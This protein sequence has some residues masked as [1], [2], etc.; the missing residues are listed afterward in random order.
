MKTLR[1]S[2]LSCLA[3]LAMA[4]IAG[5][6]ALLNSDQ[7]RFKESLV[8]TA[9]PKA[10]RASEYML[11]FSGPVGVPGV[12]LSAGSYLFRFP[13]E[14]AKVIQVLKADR[15]DVYA[16]F[17]TI[18]AGTIDRSKSSDTNEVTW[19]ERRIDAPP[20]IKAWFPSGGSVGYE[21][22][23]PKETTSAWVDHPSVEGCS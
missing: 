12:S 11:T 8:V 1:I 2:F 15:S 6:Q 7:P 5:A 18:P 9:A 22:V 21:F 16:M 20:A 19:K 23:Y 14:D 13:S 17:H 10:E 4:S 3:L